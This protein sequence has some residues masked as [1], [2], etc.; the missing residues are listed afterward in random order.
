MYYFLLESFNLIIW[1]V[2][3]HRKVKLWKT[4]PQIRKDYSGFGSI[5]SSSN[6]S[7]AGTGTTYNHS[8][9]SFLCKQTTD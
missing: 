1:T 8:S 2:V 7:C 5:S 3:E 6:R 4:K 9:M